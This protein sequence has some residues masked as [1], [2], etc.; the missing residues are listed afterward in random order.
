MNNPQDVVVLGCGLM[1]SAL[2]RTLAG[3]GASVGVW[4]RTHARAEALAGERITPVQDLGDA[5][6]S[7]RLVIACVSDYADLTAHLEG[8]SLDGILLVNLTTGA[9][10]EAEELGRFVATAGGSYLDG[11][12]INYPADVGTERASILVSGPA[13]A[14][15]AAADALAPLGGVEHVG[16][17]IAQA[18][19][20][21]GALVHLF[22]IP[23][24]VAYIEAASAVLGAGVTPETLNTQTVRMLS[25]FSNRCRTVADALASD[26]FTNTQAALGTYGRSARTFSAAYA[27]E[28]RPAVMLDAAAARLTEAEEAGLGDKAIA[29]L[30]RL[31]ARAFS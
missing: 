13:N 10:S 15:S 12:I 26:T 31:P 22:H 3:A 25:N 11:A 20:I 9:P 6:A 16:D 4:N 7:S 24:L 8:R 5:L 21:D 27:A 2:A 23:S 19:A 30:G 1:G 17:Q 28:G 14:W 29:S 18:N